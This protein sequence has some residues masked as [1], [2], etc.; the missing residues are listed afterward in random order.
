[1]DVFALRE[2]VVADY[3]RFT[4][5]F[6][7]IDAPD[8]RAYLD[9]EYAG[10]RFW[11]APLIQ[12]NPSFVAGRSVGELVAEGL[13]HPDCGPVFRVAK[14]MG[15]GLDLR[16]HLHQEQAVRIAAAD[17]SYVLTTGTGSG[18]SLSYFIPIVDRV[19]ARRRW[20]PTERLGSRRSSSIR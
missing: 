16:L 7:K 19:C 2:A 20:S 8:I 17:H 5:S 4:R 15:D 12:L 18:K 6:S 10:G 14:D 11:P 1:M 13:L 3:A 9:A